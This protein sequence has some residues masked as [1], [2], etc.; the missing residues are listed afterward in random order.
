MYP[1]H[2]RFR[3]FGRVD[4]F[5]TSKNL[6]NDKKKCAFLGYDDESKGYIILDVVDELY[7]SLHSVNLSEHDVRSKSKLMLT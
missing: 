1:G 3:V 2:A 4:R 7:R 5:V 6:P